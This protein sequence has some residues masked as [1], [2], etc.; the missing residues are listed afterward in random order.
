MEDSYVEVDFPFES[1]P[2]LLETYTGAFT[3]VR[4]GRIMEGE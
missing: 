1:D 4:V 2:V 3:S